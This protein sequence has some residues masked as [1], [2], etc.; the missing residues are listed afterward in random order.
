MSKTSLYN[1]LELLVNEYGKSNVS[2]TDVFIDYNSL[3]IFDSFVTN[4]TISFTLHDN[5]KKHI[6]DNDSKMITSI[7]PIHSINLDDISSTSIITSG[8]TFK[9]NAQDMYIQTKKLKDIFEQ[10]NQ[11][12]I[13]NPELN[14]YSNLDNYFPSSSSYS[15]IKQLLLEFNR[16]YSVDNYKNRPKFIF[17]Q[18]LKYF[19]TVC[20]YQLTYDIIKDYYEFLIKSDGS[21]GLF[22]DLNTD[23][24]KIKLLNV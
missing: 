1:E 3:N 7:N 13:Q 22:E 16:L 19:Y 2:G 12:L 10:M 20:Y 6:N 24:G 5:L 11:D 14:I 17:L 18:F 8:I 4:S 23:L 15:D 21:G 9:T